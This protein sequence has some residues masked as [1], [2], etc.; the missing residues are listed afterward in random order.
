MN[1]DV[2]Y[3]DPDDDI[4]TI[5]DKL[6]DSAAR[7]VA[8]V[9]PKRV[10][11]LQSAVNLKLLQRAAAQADKRLVLVTNDQALTALAAAT[12]IPVA[13]NLQ[14]QPSVPEIAALEVDDDDI[15]DGG[16]LPIGELAKM[17]P[18]KHES[19][20]EQVVRENAAET[21]PAPIKSP[22]SGK[23]VK[24]NPKIPNFNKFRKRLFL[25]IAGLIVLI[26]FLVWAIAFAPSAKIVITARTADLPMSQ[27][28][29][30]GPNLASDASAAT[31]KAVSQSITRQVD[32]TFN[33]TGEKEVGTKAKGQVVFQN[34]ESP[35]AITI[36]AG[37]TVSAGG[38]N[39]LT[40][41]AASVPGGSGGFG[42]CNEPGVSG[43]VGVEAADI[44]EEYN[45]ASGTVFNVSGHQNDSSTVY[46]NAVA[47]TSISGGSKKRV[48]VVT[49]ND[50][51]QARKTFA[52][53]NQQSAKQELQSKFD[54]SSL[55]L[56]ES[57]SVDMSQVAA[58]PAQDQEAPDGKAKLTGTVTYKLMGVERNLIESYLKDYFAQELK[59]SQDQRL[60]DSGAGKATLTNAKAADTLRAT[61]TATAKVGP[62]IDEGAIKKDARGK[63]YGEIQD[64]IER[65]NG[66]TNVDIKFSP[67]WVNKAPDNIDKIVIEFKIDGGK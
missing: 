29:T 45:S 1:K 53:A 17:A 36:A 52:D 34:C 22:T 23:R 9:P 30:I 54:K 49:A 25:I 62:K 26:G 60:Y 19:A 42:G 24:P 65:I 31:L 11:V 20:V 28:V 13:K 67:F 59:A 46:F 58:A 57:F 47:S 55:V 33:A 48:K 15:I 64:S 43:A 44:G 37:T 3:I 14:S 50:I 4:T 2:I 18:M 63:S 8:L 32:V 5:I 35:S 38:L 6:K 40:T 12:A 21:I 27:D 51:D 61:L 56:D 66:V 7:I 16:Q 41:E 10:G 39:Y